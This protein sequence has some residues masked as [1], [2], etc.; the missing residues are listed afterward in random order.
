MYQLRSRRIRNGEQPGSSE[1]DSQRSPSEMSQRGARAEKTPNTA[2]DQGNALTKQT[3]HASTSEPT[4]SQQDSS[5]RQPTINGH[6]GTTRESNSAGG[7]QDP[8]E[9]EQ[10]RDWRYGQCPKCE[11]R[12]IINRDGFLRRHR[13]CEGQ[14]AANEADYRRYLS[15]VG[16]NPRNQRRAVGIRR[17]TIDW[18][19]RVNQHVMDWSADPEALEV[20]DDHPNEKYSE[21]MMKLDAMTPPGGRVSQQHESDDF[22]VDGYPVGCQHPQEETADAASS[23]IH[24]DQTQMEQKMRQIQKALFINHRLGRALQILNS[25]GVASVADPQVREAIRSKFPTVAA[26]EPD[27]DEEEPEWYDE[28]Q[29]A[30]RELQ[31]QTL[32]EA[33]IRDED[34]PGW[35]NSPEWDFLAVAQLVERKKTGCG[36]SASGWSFDHVKQLFRLYPAI[37]EPLTSILSR[38]PWGILTNEASRQLLR[39]RGTALWKEGKWDIRPIGCR[40]PLLS[41]TGHMVNTRAEKD[42]ATLSGPRQVGGRVRGAA[43]VTPHL[44]RSTL[45][46][47]KDW[48]AAHR[49]AINAWGNMYRW[50]TLMS[51]ALAMGYKSEFASYAQWEMGGAPSEL[52]FE[53]PKTRTTVIIKMTEGCVQ[54]G[55]ISGSAFNVLQAIVVRE[56]YRNGTHRVDPGPEELEDVICMYDDTYLYGTP[57]LVMERTKMLERALAEVG[58]QYHRDKKRNIYGYGNQY[59]EADKRRAA[60]MGYKWL[61][62]NEGIMVTGAPVG[63]DQYERRH[64]EAKVDAIEA[65]LRKLRDVVTR[66]VTTVTRS[67]RQWVFQVVRLCMP[68][69]FNHV[70]RTVPPHNTVDAAKRLD[71]LLADFVMWLV[72]VRADATTTPSRNQL[73]EVILLQISRGGMG[74]TNSTAT[75][76]A[77]YVGSW[78]LVGE[79]IGQLRPELKMDGQFPT[80]PCMEELYEIMAKPGFRGVLSGLGVSEDSILTHSVGQ[81]QRSLSKAEA[82][83]RAASVMEALM[84]E[85]QPQVGIR[86]IG[87]ANRL[88]ERVRV[89]I[90]QLKAN[91]DTNASAWVLASPTNPHTCMN[92]AAFKTAAQVRLLQDVVATPDQPRSCTACGKPSDKQGAHSRKCQAANMHGT[93]QLL[94]AIL[95]S[96]LQEFVVKWLM[97]KRGATGYE[98][99]PRPSNFRNHFGIA[100]PREDEGADDDV[101]SANGDD[102]DDNDDGQTRRVQLKTMYGDILLVDTS[103]LGRPDIIIDVTVSESS[104]QQSSLAPGDAADYGERAKRQKWAR[105]GFIFDGYPT[106]LVVFAVD[107]SGAPGKSARAFMKEVAAADDDTGQGNQFTSWQSIA[108]LSVQMQRSRAET[109]RHIS[110]RDHTHT[111]PTARLRSPAV[112]SAL[113]EPRQN[114]P[115][116][117][118]TRHAETP[119][120]R[121]SPTVV[122]QRTRSQTS[123]LHLRGVR[124]TTSPTFRCQPASG[125]LRTDSLVNI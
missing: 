88:D 97:A 23:T 84:P 25:K 118:R 113:V 13:M 78:A 121:P 55:N 1:E 60:R 93:R 53:D 67:L 3:K 79:R 24:D 108:N 63:S 101:E 18:A 6:G 112:R 33:G 124:N 66:Q 20:K 43:E 111:T 17:E 26:L 110:A 62:A 31:L 34:G 116:P 77:A 45:Q 123:G 102:T 70:L 35:L 115:T 92:D 16:G 39:H 58:I 81:V 48:I 94:R 69:Q 82:K 49:D 14:V 64:A 119:P 125:L 27:E 120:T 15:M 73:A 7:A 106:R 42:I 104:I 54:G 28:A 52:V 103:G 100:T 72:D 85:A 71:T 57:R 47:R 87:A 91:E 75:A 83:T 95:H 51:S 109:I 76:E 29:I 122:A 86:A 38:I 98:V 90:A 46:A 74:I 30:R 32:S 99:S 21:Y 12:C 9:R 114:S 50:A 65:Q 22:G 105:A 2:E 8:T 61:D 68:A 11:T 19:A 117:P 37:V 44:L 59:T 40:Q 89:D 36:Q 96:D 4:E 41:I 5:R 10:N 56:V 80:P 107:S